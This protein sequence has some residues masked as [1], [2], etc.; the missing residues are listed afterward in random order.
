MFRAEWKVSGTSN[1]EG[2]WSSV[3]VFV[4]VWKMNGPSSVDGACSSMQCFLQYICIWYVWPSMGGVLCSIECLVQDGR[5]LV[6]YRMIGPLW[7]VW[8]SM[9]CLVQCLMFGT[10]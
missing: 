5:C 8:Y 3:E 6:Q 9:E 2:V 4:P 1:I 7:N 10:V